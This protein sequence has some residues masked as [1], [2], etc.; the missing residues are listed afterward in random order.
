M[1]QPGSEARATVLMSARLKPSAL[2][3]RWVSPVGDPLSSSVRANTAVSAAT[4]ASPNS[5]EAATS[6]H[7]VKL[8]WSRHVP[9][10]IWAG[11]EP[12]TTAQSKRAER[13]RSRI[14]VRAMRSEC[15][16]ETVGDE[17]LLCGTKVRHPEAMHA[18]PRAGHPA[19]SIAERV[20]RVEARKGQRGPGPSSPDFRALVRRPGHT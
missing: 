8:G 7:R 6:T 17:G 10:A 9:V 12:H 11:A 13:T 3:N 18:G 19:A 15:V 14:I 5:A 1:A 20:A 2:P 16:I 4:K